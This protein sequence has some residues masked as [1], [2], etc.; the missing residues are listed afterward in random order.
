[1]NRTAAKSFL[2]IRL[3]LL[4]L[5]FWLG[6]LLRCFANENVQPRFEK[7]L[8]DAKSLS[9]AEVVWVDTLLVKDPEVLKLLNVTK[10]TFSRTYRYCYIQ[11][12][13]KYRATSKLVAGTETNLSKLNV[14]TFDGT[15]FTTFCGDTRY[16]TK[17]R[18][19]SGRLPSEAG[20]H[21]LNAKFM[22]LERISE[23]GTPYSPRF[24]DLLSLESTNLLVLSAGRS[25]N[26]LL[27]ISVEGLPR[28]N[29]PKIWKIGIDEVGDLFNPKSIK[30]VSGGSAYHYRLLGYTNLGAYQ[31]P[32]RIEW[33]Q[34]SYPETSPSTLISTGLV[35][36][37]SARIP[38]RTA[39]SVFRLDEEEQLA[40]TVW[41]NIEKKFIKVSPETLELKER[42]RSQ[43]DIYG[44]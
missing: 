38:D 23:T 37:I 18:Y 17:G 39:D 5:A 44:R 36:M 35:T 34:T 32:T 15:T 20:V 29:Q 2:K 14:S 22:F 31:F 19:Y 16:M 33:V 41:D 9:G 13:M 26:G 21:P 12:G 24:T 3:P 11:S 25:S 28:G 8:N 30:Q 10:E 42:L 4:I 43:R 27:E 7:S 6:W 1:M 40:T